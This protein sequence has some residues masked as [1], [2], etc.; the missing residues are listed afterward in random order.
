VVLLISGAPA[1]APEPAAAE[2]ALPANQEP[3]TPIPPA[4]EIDPQKLALGESLF[5]DTRLSGNG[6]RSCASCHDPRHQRRQRRT[7]R[8]GARWG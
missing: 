7:I 4:P 6:L 5:R 2:P 1:Q 3:I 8:Q